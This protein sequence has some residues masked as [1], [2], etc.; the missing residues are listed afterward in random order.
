MLRD[1]STALLLHRTA[2]FRDTVGNKHSCCAPDTCRKS[3]KGTPEL[4][5]QKSDPPSVLI[6]TDRAP[7]GEDDQSTWK[8]E[9]RFGRRTLARDVST[10][11]I[12][13]WAVLTSTA[14]SLFQ[15]SCCT[16]HADTSPV[17]CQSTRQI[18]LETHACGMHAPALRLPLVLPHCAANL[19]TP[20]T[21]TA[22]EQAPYSMPQALL[23][24]PRTVLVAKQQGRQR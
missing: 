24:Q 9:A 15:S 21:L 11:I 23:L 16:V 20:E 19:V 2:N 6:W 14:P 3:V 1:V 8:Q 10:T 17:T 13:H 12:Q 7:G 22:L 4:T 18:R 5:S